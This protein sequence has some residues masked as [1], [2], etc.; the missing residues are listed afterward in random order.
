MRCGVPKHY[1]NI[2]IS[3]VS[4]DTDSEERYAKQC[5]GEVWPGSFC[6]FGF[7]RRKRGLESVQIILPA[8]TQAGQSSRHR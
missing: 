5:G 8:E 1:F 2:G 7:Q 3:G 4:Q 6:H